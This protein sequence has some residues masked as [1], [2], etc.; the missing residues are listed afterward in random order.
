MALTLNFQGRLPN[1]SGPRFS[2]EKS[3]MKLY[4]WDLTRRGC[5]LTLRAPFHRAG[6]TYLKMVVNVVQ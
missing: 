3:G 6:F 4:L 5:K 1:H 2:Q